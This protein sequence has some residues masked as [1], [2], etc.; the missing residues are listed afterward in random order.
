MLRLRDIMT[1]DVITLAPDMTLRSAMEL[2]STHQISG[3]PVKEGNRVIGVISATDIVAFATNPPEAQPA[4]MGDPPGAA[5]W[6]NEGEWDDESGRSSDYFSQRWTEVPEEDGGSTE[7]STEGDILDNYTVSN[8]MTWGV[9]SLPAAADVV[10]AA[11]VMRSAGIHRMLVMEDGRL[12]GIVSTMDLVKAVA[13]NRI[14]RRTYVFDT[15]RG[16]D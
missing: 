7:L 4:D 6:D 2:F 1:T 11:E 5:D 10:S 12:L 3:A 15:P 16:G 14:V 8:A 13:R 9:Y